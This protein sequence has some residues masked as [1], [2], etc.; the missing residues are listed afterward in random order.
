MKLVQRKSKKG[1]EI[2]AL[3]PYSTPG[4]KSLLMCSLNCDSDW[5]KVIEYNSTVHGVQVIS[6]SKEIADSV[7]F[8]VRDKKTNNRAVYKIIDN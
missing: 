7:Y 1:T 3:L 6:S 2:W 8:S 5:S 4:T